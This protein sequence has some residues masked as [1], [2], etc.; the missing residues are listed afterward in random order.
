MYMLHAVNAR[1]TPTL[2]SVVNKV[3]P[4]VPLPFHDAD[5]SS[6]ATR[7]FVV[8]AKIAMAD[9]LALCYDTCVGSLDAVH[10]VRG[11]DRSLQKCL[12]KTVVP[13]RSITTALTLV[14]IDFVCGCVDRLSTLAARGGS[15]ILFVF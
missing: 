7:R 5:E 10:W 1:T 13:N 3:E 12:R 6:D 9:I 11:W 14:I 8:D 15:C 2:T 4:V